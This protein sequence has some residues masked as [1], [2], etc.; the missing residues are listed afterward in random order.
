M[1]A[2]IFR[3]LFKPLGLI[4]QIKSKKVQIP[5][6]NAVLEKMYRKGQKIPTNMVL[7]INSLLIPNCFIKYLIFMSFERNW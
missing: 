4:L 2:F 1:S 7:I 3:Y 5:F 6:E